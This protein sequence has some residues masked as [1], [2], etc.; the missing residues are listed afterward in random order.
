M[1]RPDFYPQLPPEI[2]NRLGETTFG[3]QRAI[4][5]VEHLL[6]ILHAPPAPEDH[7]REAKVFLRTPDGRYFCN[8]RE[9]GERNFREL[10]ASYQ[11]LYE[12]YDKAYDEAGSAQDLFRILEALG[13][14][15]RA[16]AN[17]LGAV[18]SAREL[19]G[20]DKLLIAARD[21]AYEV[22]RSLDLLLADARMA[23]DYRIA[24]NAETQAAG[25]QEM[26]VAGHKLNVLA[27]VTFPLM[28]VATI[29]GMNLT[30]GMEDNGPLLFWG[31]FGVGILVGLA[32][33]SWVTLGKEKARRPAGS[34]RPQRDPR[35]RNL[36]R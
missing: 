32:T 5:E 20:K 26:A 13:P 33:K 11:Q 19:V 34:R 9:K 10:L 27:A 4:Y 22:S 18:Q 21:E 14:I 6:L 1:K 31:V 36:R 29:F 3:R 7:R 25:A 23:L 35:N 12:R 30:S 17:L 16:A 24:E 15:S 8:G 2:E 28:A